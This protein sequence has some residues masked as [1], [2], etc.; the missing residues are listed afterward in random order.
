[1]AWTKYQLFLAGLMLVTGSINTLSAKWADNFVAQGCGGSKEHSFQHPFLQAVGMFLGEFSCLAAFYLLRC[2]A[3]RLP[4]ASVDLQQPFNPLLFLPPALCDMTG[5]SIMYVA[6]NMTSASS[7]QMLRGAVIIFTGLFSVAFLGRRLVL[8]QWLGILTTIAGLVVVGLADLLSKHDDQH[9]LSEVITGDLLIIMAQVIVAI[10]MV[11]EEKFVY[12][13]NVHPLRAVG[14]EGLFG[15]VILSLL[16]VPM[17]YIPAGSFSGN[18]RG[19]LEDALDAFCQV[20]RQPLIALALLGNISSIAF[21][22]FAGISVTK[23]LSATTRMVLDS[24][25]TVV[26]WALSLA[27]GWEAFHSLQIL[28]FLILLTGTAL[29][30][31]LHRPLLARLS[32]G[33]PL[34]DEGEQERLLDA[35]RTP[36]NDTS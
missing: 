35:S 12:K 21:F 34:A 11:L 23:E 15:F 2:R 32:R 3:A 8:S 25:R 29:Y 14:T 5:T 13:H 4:D 33:R 19:T 30:N 26:I 10:Q 22:N 16:L 24:L 31:G 27:L 7:F 6:L 20:G 18:P 28:G 36:I 1:M 9:K 17:Y